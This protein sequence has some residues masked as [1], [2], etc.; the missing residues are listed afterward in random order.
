MFLGIVLGVL[1][2]LAYFKFRTPGYSTQPSGYTID[3][4]TESQTEEVYTIDAPN[5]RP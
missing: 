1:L 4:P 3:G 5:S 2:L